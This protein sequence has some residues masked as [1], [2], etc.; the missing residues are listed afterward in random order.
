MNDSNLKS[1]S[2]LEQNVEKNLAL[3][4]FIHFCHDCWFQR[5]RRCCRR[6]HHNCSCRRNCRRRRRQRRHRRRLQSSASYSSQSC[7]VKRFLFFQHR[8]SG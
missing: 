3:K 5:F 8:P 6:S 2:Q 7:F 1:Q 4:N